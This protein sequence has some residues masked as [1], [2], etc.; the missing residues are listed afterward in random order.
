M[1]C[2]G[3]VGGGWGWSWRAAVLACGGGGSPGG[4]A[5]CNAGGSLGGCG[6]GGCCGGGCCGGCCSPVGP[7]SAQCVEG[8]RL[9]EGE[10]A[11][12]AWRC[13]GS[14]GGRA[15]VE[16]P[17]LLLR[18]DAGGGWGGSGG[19]VWPACAPACPSRA[20]CA[21]SCSW[22]C[23]SSWYVCRCSRRGDRGR[24]DI[25]A[26]AESAAAAVALGCSV[27]ALRARQ[28]A[29]RFGPARRALKQKSAHDSAAGGGGS[30]G[31]NA[32]LQSCY[33]LCV[34][35]QWRGGLRTRSA[36]SQRRAARRPPT[37]APA[38]R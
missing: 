10:G 13:C 1:E 38:P 26:R 17:L 21:R 20:P 15:G 24:D 22:C 7:V 11:G 27:P 18:A 8:S 28:K 9:G 6:A 23:T 35:L 3:C 2:G 29:G 34:Q 16:V 12:A 5:G 32:A 31:H 19:H 4:G 36:A 33:A 37:C 14:S 30:G 25:L